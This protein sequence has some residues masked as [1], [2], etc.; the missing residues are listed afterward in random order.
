MGNTVTDFSIS[1]TQLYF[2]EKNRTF[3]SKLDQVQAWQTNLLPNY[4]SQNLRLKHYL[5][6]FQILY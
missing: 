5:S 6:Y 3:Y 1:Q 2:I 4:E